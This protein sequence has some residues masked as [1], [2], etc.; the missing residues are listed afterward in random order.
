MSSRNL[1]LN[2]LGPALDELKPH[3]RTWTFRAGQHL[4]EPYE[5]V[6]RVIFPVSGLISARAVL[7][8]GHE[9]ECVLVGRTNAL[10][11]TAAIGSDLSLTRDICLTDTHAWGIELGRLRSLMAANRLVDAQVRRF[12]FAQ[13]GYAVQMGVCNAMHGAEPRL[14]R[15]LSTAADL[16]NGQDIRMAQEE[17]AKSLGVQR[18]ALS[19]LLQRFKSQGLI[20]VRRGHM[21]LLDRKGL[22]ARACEC[23]VALQRAARLDATTSEFAPDGNPFGL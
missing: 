22:A 7:E 9:L 4:N 16:L 17:L 2:S 1:L 14:A 6:S 3:L 21:R 10:G 13:M 18:S 8:S 11:G 15:W 12:S 5:R 23:R 19:P 20:E